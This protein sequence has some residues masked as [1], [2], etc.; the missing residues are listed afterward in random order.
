MTQSEKWPVRALKDVAD[1]DRTSVSSADIRRGTLYVGLQHMTGDGGFVG[2]ETVANGDLSS[3]KFRF[4]ERHVLY[5]KLRPYLRKI[6]SPGF[7]GV[8]STEIIPILPRDGLDR[9]YLMHFLRQ[10]YMVDF[11]TKRSAGAN[12]PRISPKE[13]AKFR[14]PVPPLSE[15]RRIAAI[16][17]R[18]DEIRRKRQQAIEFTG[19]LLRSVFLNM[20]GDPMTNSKRLPL[21]TF[22]EE[23]VDS[24]Y[25]PRFYNEPYSES[26][27]RIIRI[28]D[29][30]EAGELEFEAMPRHDLDDS[31]LAKSAVI[32]GD[33]IFARTGA[34]VGKTALM[35]DAAPTCVPGAYFIRLRF[36]ERIL[37]AFAR[38]T[39]A[40]PPIQQHIAV[41]SRQSAQQNFSGPAIR[42]LPISV[43]PMELQLR[44][45]AIRQRVLEIRRRQQRAEAHAN[46]LLESLS[47]K[48]F[49]GEL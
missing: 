32:P 38:D 49:A 4:D 14:I 2:V 22:G 25:G 7:A 21:S 19:E 26:G 48:A 20:F 44:Y 23:L 3:N 13:V 8:C 30:N 47:Q 33:V 36:S 43:P 41:K 24:T 31:V 29:L 39:L 10:P 18:A 45:V 42:R 34:T 9:R 35:D 28:T 27:T 1:L 5:G 12:L 11:A 40:S 16:L 37:P 17:D 6:A 15:Q 46:E